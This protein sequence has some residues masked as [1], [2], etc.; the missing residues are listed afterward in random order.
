MAMKKKHIQIITNE[1]Y[2]FSMRN[3]WKNGVF[4]LII[5]FMQNDDETVLTCVNLS[6][7]ILV[8]NDKYIKKE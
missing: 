3:S 6:A 4:L 1:K 8:N 2:C 5:M 7:N